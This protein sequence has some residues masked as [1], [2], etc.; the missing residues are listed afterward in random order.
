[1]SPCGGGLLDFATPR[2]AGCGLTP[3]LAAGIVLS[4]DGAASS[5]AAFPSG[6]KRPAD[7]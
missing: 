2:S 6:T 5:G 1:M 4:V 3:R 7:G